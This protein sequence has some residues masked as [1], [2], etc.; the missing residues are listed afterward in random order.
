MSRLS[1]S[2]F[3]RI[4]KFRT[5]YTVLAKYKGDMAGVHS[6]DTKLVTK[7]ETFANGQAGASTSP[8]QQDATLEACI[9]ANIAS[10]RRS[11]EI[12]EARFDGNY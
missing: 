6:W 1:K 9:A 3:F 5:T 2:G 4:S 12:G 8:P 10:I 7:W 11:R